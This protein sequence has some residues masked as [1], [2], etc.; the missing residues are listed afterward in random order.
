M[1]NQ[2]AKRSRKSC[3][4]CAALRSPKSYARG[5][6]LKIKALED[7]SNCELILAQP[8]RANENI[9]ELY[10]ALPPVYGEWSGLK[11]V[12]AEGIRLVFELFEVGQEIQADYYNRITFF[13]QE[14]M[15]IRQDL[16]KKKHEAENRVDTAKKALSSGLP[17]GLS[18]K[19]G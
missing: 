13:H 17:K 15:E 16:D 6:K 18:I 8:S 12:T 9:I 19:N 10:S 5:T 3:K 11:Q 7:C 2:W 1:A 4:T 14:L